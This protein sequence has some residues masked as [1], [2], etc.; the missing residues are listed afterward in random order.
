MHIDEHLKKADAFEASLARLDPLRDGELY[1]V[2]LMRA[3]TNRINAALHVLGT[4]TDGPATEQKLGDLN[5]TYKPPMNSPAPESL[6][7][8]FTALAFIENLRPDI[9]RGPKRL[10]APAAQRALDAYTLIKRD[11]NSV[12]GRKSP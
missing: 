4:T 12:L 6:K 3:G 10:D 2:F 1:A 5:H 8:S 7:A 9:V 11:T